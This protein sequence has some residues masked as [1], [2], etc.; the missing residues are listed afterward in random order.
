MRKGGRFQSVDHRQSPYRANE[1]RIRLWRRARVREERGT[2]A[3]AEVVSRRENTKAA[4]RDHPRPHRPAEPGPALPDLTVIPDDVC[5]LYIIQSR[6]T[7]RWYIGITQNIEKRLGEHNRGCAPSTRPYIPYTLIYSEKYKTKTLARKREIALKKSGVTR[8]VLRAQL[9][10]TALSSNGQ[11]IGFFPPYGGTAPNGGASRVTH[12]FTLYVLKSTNN[13]RYY[14][15]VTDDL[16]Q[17]LIKHNTGSVRSTKAFT[18]YTVV[19]TEQYSS[20]SQ[21]RQK[22]RRIKR[23]GHI[24]RYL[25]NFT[26]LSSNGQDIG[27]SSR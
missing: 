20:L 24:E 14:V 19:H 18:P 17:R 4:A 12:M 25:K 26:A 8:K 16:Q 13:S 2:R 23:S 7:G 15:G 6:T 3:E 10:L 11:D 27:F 22:E 5:F 9:Q 21:A 1:E